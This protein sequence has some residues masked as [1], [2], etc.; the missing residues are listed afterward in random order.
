MWK[1]ST[2]RHRPQWTIWLMRTAC[3]IRKATN[4]NSEYVI[5]TVFSHDYSGRTKAPQ[6]YADVY[7]DCLGLDIVTNVH[8]T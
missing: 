7:I 8:V 3:W 6:C 1:Y 5:V 2:E 4:I